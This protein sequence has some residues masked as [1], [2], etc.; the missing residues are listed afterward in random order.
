L[1]LGVGWS[2]EQLDFRTLSPLIK[3]LAPELG[4]D[5]TQRVGAYTQ[6]LTLDLRD[7]PVEPRLGAYASV[8]SAVATQY[9]GSAY[10]FVQFVPEVRGY[11]PISSVTLAGRLRLG[12]FLGGDVPPTERF[13]SGGAS[14]HRGFGERKLAPSVYGVIN[15]QKHTVPYGG[16]ALLET[17]LEARFPITT[18]REIGIGGAVFLDGG[19][20]AEELSA[21]QPGALY[22]AAGVGLRLHTIVGPLRA[23][24][25]YRLNRKG[26][27]DLASDSPIAFHLSLGEAF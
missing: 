5:H 10:E 9:A 2:I 27:G 20:V 22:W 7:H 11:V 18:W 8:R 1:Q 17:G 21:I 13:F 16:A 6:T 12:T 23:D 24:L 25:G 15:G 4:L 14:N 3:P 19:D 26:P